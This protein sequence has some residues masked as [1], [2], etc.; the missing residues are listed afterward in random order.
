MPG[1]LL[2]MNH[3]GPQGGEG[4]RDPNRA[5]VNG[6]HPNQSASGSSGAQPASASQMDQLPPEIQ[7]IAAQYHP[8]SK[9]LSRTSQECFNKLQELLTTMAGMPVATQPSGPLTN[10]AGV[11]VAT[12]GAGNTSQNNVA[13]KKHLMQFAE[14]QRAKFIKL[15]VIS[16]WARRAP[17]IVKIIDLKAWADMQI[18][19]LDTA[20]GDMGVMR[21]AMENARQPNPDIRTALEILSTGK[22]SWMPD[23]SSV[24]APRCGLSLTRT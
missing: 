6:N 14:E 23:V 11:H 17:E 7:H 5:L 18:L 15:L 20:V 19:E 3:N 21:L 4:A 10:G 8:L 22:A 16:Q 24:N 12:N 13:K 1:L 9:L 2:K